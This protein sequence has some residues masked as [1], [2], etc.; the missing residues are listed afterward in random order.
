MAEALAEE[1]PQAAAR[2][3]AARGEFL[4]EVRCEEIPA[5]MLEAAIKEL[6]QRTFEDLMGRGLGPREVETGFTPRRLVLVLKGLPARQDD[7]VVSEIGPPKAA[8]FGADGQPTPAAVG[9]ARK[10]GVDVSELR[11]KDFSLEETPLGAGGQAGK[12]KAKPTGERVY[13]ERHVPGKPTP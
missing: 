12:A 11:V 10:C 13:V 8:A 7:Q 2:D 9:F 4:L 6:T 3:A 1:A 5:R